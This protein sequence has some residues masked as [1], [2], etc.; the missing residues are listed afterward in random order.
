MK[1]NPKKVILL[2]N[3]STMDLFC[4][5]DLVENITKV[6]KKITVQ[7]NGGTVSVAHKATFPGYKH[8]VWFS[9]DAITNIISI[10]TLINKYRVTYDIMDQ[11]FLVHREGLKKP[12]MESNMHKY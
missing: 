2:E 9:K 4:N 7:G 5:L 11:I 12:N 6:G 8:Y 3:C 1:F 10:K